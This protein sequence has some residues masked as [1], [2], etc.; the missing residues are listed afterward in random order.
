MNPLKSI[1]TPPTTVNRPFIDL[2]HPGLAGEYISSRYSFGWLYRE[3]TGSEE[4]FTAQIDADIK[5]YEALHTTIAN[6]LGADLSAR[7]KAAARWA[8]FLKP[9]VER[10][11]S[12]SA[13]LAA[14]AALI[15]AGATFNATVVSHL[16][17][18]ASLAITAAGFVSSAMLLVFRFGVDRQRLWYKYLMAHLEA[19]KLTLG[20]A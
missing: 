3:S 12:R 13:T 5:R 1:V 9:R 6:S 7:G 11:D 10:L 17:G 8:S 4:R 20:P 16:N 19:L 14:S 18:G 2:L 15:A